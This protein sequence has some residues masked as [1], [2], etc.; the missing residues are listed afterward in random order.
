M[1]KTNQNPGFF[2]RNRWWIIVLAAVA[3]VVLLAS[4]MGGRRGTVLV[5]AAQVTRGTITST[6]ATDGKVR[7]INNFEAHAP[8][9][10][11]VK[12]V[13]VREGEEVKP[14][15]MLVVLD[16]ADAEAQAAK[17]Q[18]Q[19]RAAEADLQAVRAGGT[20]EEVLTNQSQLV[21]AKADRDAAQRNFQAL[22][23]LE[24][25]GAASPAE[26]EAAAGQVKTLEA[27][28]N[29]LEQKLTNRYSSPEV[30]RAQAQLTEAQAA[31]TAAEDL[32]R[33]SEIRAPRAGLVYSLPV[34]AGSFVNAGDLIVQV[35]DLSQVEV[36]GYVDEPDIGKLRVGERV[37]ITWDALPGRTWM[38]MVSQ[39]P[40]TV[41]KMGTRTVGE[42]TC[43]VNN[44]DLKLLPNIN[45]SVNIVTGQDENV[46][47]VPREAVHQ[48]D[49]QRYLYAIV[50]GE[51]TRRDI[52]TSLSNLTS[53]EV[54][55]GVSDGT[56]IAVAALNA[57]PMREGTPVRV[58]QK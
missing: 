22:Q 23:R 47:I 21:K 55:N 43:R 9:A 1:A 27:Q 13:S 51:L 11:S 44:Q 50:N 30:A 15:Q 20:H 57:A 39:I 46:L 25:E 41:V 34:K 29:L 18:A 10:V 8:A 4:S 36:I 2:R 5:R 45:V 32:V 38:G 37:N 7:P 35:A 48:D 28:V 31:Y 42:I 49:G 16:N 40:T 56:L 26:V 24:K 6:I 3:A 33:H 19:I 14:G 53:M 17:A 52:Q 58:V 12:Q 54:T